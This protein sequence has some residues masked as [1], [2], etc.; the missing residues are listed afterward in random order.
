M[1]SKILNKQA[2]WRA[3]IKHFTSLPVM[4]IQKK[5]KVP[6]KLFA[7]LIPSESI[8]P[9]QTSVQLLLPVSAPLSLDF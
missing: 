8:P 6:Q 3:G 9:P 2:L 1:L 5:E 7:L 4:S